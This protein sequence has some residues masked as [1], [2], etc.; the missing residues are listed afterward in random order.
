ME[1]KHLAREQVKKKKQKKGGG[2][3]RGS[4]VQTKDNTQKCKTLESAKMHN[5]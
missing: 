4:K 3:E 5:G 2:G 1:K